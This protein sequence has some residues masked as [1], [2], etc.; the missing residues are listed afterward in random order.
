[1]I[2]LGC[3]GQ[4]SQVQGF[5]SPW[6]EGVPQFETELTKLANAS[7]L[8]LVRLGTVA[9][10]D[11]IK[12]TA[13]AQ[14]LIVAA[15]IAAFRSSFEDIK[16]DGVVGHSVGE[17][18]AAAISGV[19]SDQDAMSL[20][21]TR[22]EAMAR[23]AAAA[24]TSMAAILGGDRTEIEA[25]LD[26]LGLSVANFNGAGQVVAAGL[27]SSIKLLLEN[28]PERARIIGL[29]VAGAFHTAFMDSAQQELSEACKGI[30][31]NDPEIM[32][33]SN[34]NGDLVTSGTAYL[35]SLVKQ[36]SNP[37]RWDLCME[38]MPQEEFIFAELP[39]AGA[40]AGLVK[41]GVGQSSPVTLK[42]P[43]DIEK[44]LA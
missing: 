22:G 33:W 13:I 2:I 30:Q 35:D 34:S 21:K 38:S 8:D 43:S 39:P 16:V 4:G 31:T 32:L 7:G 19:L 10:E 20:V 24:D 29:K 27:M 9:Q 5:L 28:P 12:D 6:L 17:F 44:V 40:L 11:E 42:L 15:S 25:Q 23:A 1:M 14:P 41:R 18:A 37:V 26:E 3:P 36:V